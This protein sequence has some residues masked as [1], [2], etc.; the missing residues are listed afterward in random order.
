MKLNQMGRSL[1]HEATKIVTENSGKLGKEDQ[2]RA[3]ITAL[4]CILSYM[5][6]YTAQDRS[7]QLR[8]RAGDV[9]GTWKTLLPLCVSFG[10]FTQGMTYLDG[11][12]LHLSAVIAASICTQVALR[13]PRSD[14][15]D[16]PQ[17]ASQ[18]E[19]AK[20]NSSLLKNFALLSEHHIKL[21][22]YTQ[23]SRTI[24]PA[25]DIQ[26]HFPKTWTGRESMANIPKEGEKFRG[27]KLSGPYFL[28]IQNDTTPIQAVRF[29]LRFLSEYCDTER[30]DY[31]LRVSLDRSD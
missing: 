12:R 9:E 31:K 30:L 8:G 17:D 26:K 23:E 3:A 24:L 27:G 18:S 1:K 15:H 13:A 6:A 10:R 7:N 5:A 19:L 29:G 4:E 28:P 14:A 11:L 16:S 25:E 20:Q 21:Q 2:K 22:R